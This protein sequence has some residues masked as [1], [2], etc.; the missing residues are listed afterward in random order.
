[1]KRIFVC[2]PSLKR[3]LLLAII[4]CNQAFSQQSAAVFYGSQ[5]PVN[6]L[7]NYNIIIVDPYSDL[8]PKRD[9]PNSKIF[10]Y[11]SLG[12]VSLD[13]PYFKLIQPNWVIGKNE[14]WNNNKVL[15]QTNPG[16][17]KFFLNQIIEPLWQKGYRG[18]FLD[19]LDSYYLAVHD[20]KLQEKQIKGM[21]ETIRQIKIRHP[22]AKIILNRGFVLLPYIHSDIYAVLI[23]SL[24]NAWHQQERAYEETPPAERKQL[25][26]E[27]NKIRAMN[28]PII[29][30]DYL[31]PNQQY[32]AKELAEQL[33]KQGF[34]PWITDSLLQSIYIRKYPEM[35]RQILVA[36]TN[37]LPV[38][39]GAPLQFVGPILEHMGYIPKYLDLNKITQL[40]SGDLSKRYAGIVLWLIDPVK[41]DSFMGWVQTQIENKIPVVFLNSFGVPYADPELTKLGLFVSSEKESDASLRIAKMD[42]KFIGHEIAPILTPYDFVVL[43]AASSQILLKVKNVYEQTSDVVAITPWGGYA[44]IPDVIQYMPNL[45]TRWVINP[46]PF[47]R[48]ALRLQDFPIPDTTTENGRRLMSV[49]IDG[50]GFSYPARWIGG[51]IA[52]VELRDRILTRFPIPTSVS[53]ITGEIAPNGNQPKKSPELM[54]VAR[55]IFA[56]PWVEIASHTFSHPLN[57][58]P[59]SKRFNELGEESTYGMRI[60]NYKFNLATEITGSVD[61]IN[62]NLAP[63]DKKCHLFF[64]SGLAGP[65]KEALAL[66]YKDNLLNINGVSGTHIDKNDPSLTG[67]RPRGLELGGYYQVFAPIDLDFYY[68]NNLAGPL[69]G[70]E[71]VIQTLELTDKPHRYKPID[72][73]YHFYSASYPAALQALI[74]VYQWALNQ[75]VM[76]IFISDYIKKVLDFYQTSIGKIDG[77]WVITT[78]GEVREFRS[79][80]HF[81]YPDLINSK[82]VIGFKKINDELYIHLGSSHF[83]TLKY[84]KTEPTQPYLI[85][86]NARIV[87]Y[88]RKKKKLSVKFAGYMPVQFTFANVAQ[89]KMSSKF[90]L[91]ATHNSDKTISYS[92]SETNNEIHFDC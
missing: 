34:I 27:I 44:L 37:K 77:S 62:K 30:V 47:F 3:L 74:K 82:N 13:S 63:A 31:P 19:T 87:D 50:D 73:Y 59:Q 17:Q 83:T 45:S 12:E 76:N 9:C 18:F 20:P 41:N 88:S 28:L 23:E 52:A 48:K 55:S 25:F 46:F 64:W 2:V 33:S 6:Q 10:A 67:I 66:T 8:N 42:P 11:A 51:R 53:V 81:G 39:F 5:I 85:E 89:C 68:M 15:D 14:A 38:R 4:F 36:Y 22:D 86:A 24:Y 60:P 43:N 91:K 72:L 58:Q 49:H 1:M 29:I 21:V 90:P 40:P 57:W 71:K 7:C 79:P 65:S 70:Y 80:L 84:Q 54:E 75:P 32:K 61:F 35:Q 69:Y 92:S 26:E 16:W 78:N 56:L